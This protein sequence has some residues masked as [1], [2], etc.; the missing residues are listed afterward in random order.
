LLRQRE[1]N[2]ADGHKQEYIQR[3]ADKVCFDALVVLLFHLVLLF[4]F[5]LS[6][7]ER[8]KKCVPQTARFAS[9]ERL[10]AVDVAHGYIWLTALNFPSL[11]SLPCL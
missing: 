7:I 10:A 2:H 1:W 5:Y 9:L 3:A 4:E 6:F 11:I 8:I